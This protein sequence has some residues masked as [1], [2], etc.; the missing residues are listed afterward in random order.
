MKVTEIVISRSIRVNTG[1]YEGTD[2]FISAKAELD[3]LDDFASASADLAAQVEEQMVTQ[4]RA[5]YGVRNVKNLL[6]LSAIRKHHGLKGT[7]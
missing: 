3:E 6:E 1:N 2:H 4:L 5:H 7:K